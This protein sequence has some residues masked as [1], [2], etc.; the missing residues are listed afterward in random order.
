MT[1]TKTG[2]SS[3]IDNRYKIIET[4]GQGSSGVVYKVWDTLEDRDIILKQ[5]KHNSSVNECVALDSIQHEGVPRILDRGAGYFTMEY[6]E[7]TTLDKLQLPFD[8]WERVAADIT[9]TLKAIHDA[10][11]L[12][13][14]LKPSHILCPL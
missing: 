9:R 12:H 8:G 1:T 7:G 13:G 3:L 4:L 10:G 2:S 11:W 6:V 5:I 14:D